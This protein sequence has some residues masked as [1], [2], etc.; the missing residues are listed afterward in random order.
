MTD[1]KPIVENVTFCTFCF[2][3]V[4][5]YGGYFECKDC[6]AMGVFIGMMSNH[7]C[8]ADWAKLRKERKSPMWRNNKE[9][10]G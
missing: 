4:D 10:K 7:T 9:A 6:G 5:R 1:P 2:G 3:Q 8:H